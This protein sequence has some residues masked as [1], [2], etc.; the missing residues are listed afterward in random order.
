MIFEES[1]KH[2]LPFRNLCFSSVALP[3][4]A[5]AAWAPTEATLA[6]CAAPEGWPRYEPS[7]G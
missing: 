4:V 6:G 3:A 7:Y 2:R 1:G 5:L